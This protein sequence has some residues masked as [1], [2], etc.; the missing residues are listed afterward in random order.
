MT[1]IFAFF[2]AVKNKDVFSEKIHQYNLETKRILKL[3]H[4]KEEI[5]SIKI[6]RFQFFK[7]E[8]TITNSIII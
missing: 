4:Q 7:L 8:H 3:V 2:T 1:G 5:R 6:F